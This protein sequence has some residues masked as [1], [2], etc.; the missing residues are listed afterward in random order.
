[1]SAAMGGAMNGC[2]LLVYSGVAPD[3][4]DVAVPVDAVLLATFVLP[5]PAFADPIDGIITNNPVT[6]A[7]TIAAGT[8]TWFRVQQ[9]DSTVLW[10]GAVGFFG[11]DLNLDVDTV[12]EGAQLSIVLWRLGMADRGQF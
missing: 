10:Q 8:P 2:N 4:A 6:P 5:T 9:I 7:I 12:A 1:M 3:S 11:T